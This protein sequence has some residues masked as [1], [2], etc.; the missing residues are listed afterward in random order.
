M[1]CAGCSNVL[2]SFSSPGHISP[3]LGA[4]AIAA[5]LT[6]SLTFGGSSSTVDT[7]ISLSDW[8][9]WLWN[10]HHQSNNRPFP[11]YTFWRQSRRIINGGSVQF[12]WSC[13]S[14]PRPWNWSCLMKFSHNS[15]H[16]T[17][18]IFLHWLVKISAVKKDSRKHPASFMIRLQSKP[19]CRVLAPSPCRFGNTSTTALCWVIQA[20]VSSTYEWGLKPGCDATPACHYKL[21]GIWPSAFPRFFWIGQPSVMVIYCLLFV[22]SMNSASSSTSS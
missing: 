5:F 14:E 15:F 18:D 19:M 3:L 8:T 12:R 16:F 17:P 2:Q 1:A 4:A 20:N 6:G 10:R 11:Q 13:G 21:T 22:W 9:D 7:T